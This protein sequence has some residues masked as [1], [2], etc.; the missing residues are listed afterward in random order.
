MRRLWTRGQRA[1]YRA[2]FDPPVCL[3][4]FELREKARSLSMAATQRRLREKTRT[5]TAY[6][7]E[8]CIEQQYDAAQ[9]ELLST[10]RDRLSV[11]R[12][13]TVKAHSSGWLAADNA[14]ARG[15]FRP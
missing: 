13:P 12:L 6:T 1:H 3:D 8:G 2:I 15:N 11:R 9:Y 14:A 5:R 7:T 10:P 4:S